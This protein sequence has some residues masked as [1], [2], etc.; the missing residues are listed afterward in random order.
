VANVRSSI[1]ERVFSISRSSGGG[2]KYSSST[3]TDEI[4]TPLS[5]IKEVQHFVD[6]GLGR[7]RARSHSDGADEVIG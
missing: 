6:E 5:G 1:A 4:S 7:G 2:G 3:V